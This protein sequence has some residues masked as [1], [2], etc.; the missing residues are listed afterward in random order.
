MDGR[1]A[2]GRTGGLL[3]HKAAGGCLR[4]GGRCAH[5]GR[6]RA[7]DLWGAP[8]R[9]RQVSAEDAGTACTA[10]RWSCSS[11]DEGWRRVASVV[12][13]GRVEGTL[14]GNGAH[15]AV[16][17]LFAHVDIPGGQRRARAQHRRRASGCSCRAPA[18]TTP[19]Q[20]PRPRR[21]RV[22][23]VWMRC[24]PVA[25]A[26]VDGRPDVHHGDRVPARGLGSR[27]RS[28]SGPGGG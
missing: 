5:T 15:L 7:A 17:D 9:R 14:W 27:L 3:S 10:G 4:P 20:Q 19:W 8:S 13:C 22:F 28:R 12:K 11:T 18:A 26:A 21:R 2:R 23:I 24:S 1:R 25:T 6:R 16:A